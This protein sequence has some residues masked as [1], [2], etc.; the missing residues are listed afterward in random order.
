MAG[1]EAFYGSRQWGGWKNMVPRPFNMFKNVA[2]GVGKGMTNLVVVA[3]RVAG[4]IVFFFGL[5][6]SLTQGIIALFD[7]EYGKASKAGLDMYVATLGA[8]GGPPGWLVSGIYF[9]VDYTVGWDVAINSGAGNTERTRE[10]LKDPGW[11]PYRMTGA[12]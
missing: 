3:T 7:E 2:Y 8:L 12:P 10:I 11:N 6:V 1:K 9:A 4:K 5:A